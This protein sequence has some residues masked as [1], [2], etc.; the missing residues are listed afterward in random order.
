MVINKQIL[1]DRLEN[2]GISSGSAKVSYSWDAITHNSYVENN[3]AASADH[4]INSVI[5][6][7]V[8]PGLSVG[9]TNH[10]V[11]TSHSNSTNGGEFEFNDV[12]SVG[13]KV[14]YD[15][16]TA[17]LNINESLCGNQTDKVRSRVLLTSM[18]DPASLSGFMVGVNGSNK[19]FYEYVNSDGVREV[20]VLNHVIGDR[21]LISISNSKT[22]NLVTMG[23]Y[24]PVKGVGV[25]SSF[26]INSRNGSDKLYVGGTLSGIHHGGT[27]TYE[28]D[29]YRGFKGY[30]ENFLLLSGYHDESYLNKISDVFFL[31]AYT[32]GTNTTSQISYNTVTGFS[33]TQVVAGQGITGYQMLT[34]NVEDNQGNITQVLEETPM[35]GNIYENKITYLTG[36]DT[37]SSDST[38]FQA[39][40]KTFDNA[41]IKNY[42][43]PCILWDSSFS[44]TDKYEVYRCD[45]HSNKINLRSS[46]KNRDLFPLNTG[47]YNLG[48]KINVYVNGKIQESGVDYQITAN[49]ELSGVARE[50]LEDD[51]V[52]Y[53]IIDEDQNWFDFT[54]WAGTLT[55]GASENKDVYL[56]K[57][58]LIS[59]VDYQ[60]NGSNL[61]IFATN[62]A[63]GRMA[64]IPRHSGT[65]GNYNGT[66]TNHGNCFADKII[67]E[68]VWVG[69]L[70]SSEKIDYNKKTKCDISCDDPDPAGVS[71][72]F[73]PAKINKVFGSPKMVG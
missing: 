71:A 16:W 55:Y 50:Y 59:G 3:L 37:A 48:D 10:P 41:Y 25:Y 4:V 61:E 6:A 12:L 62:F 2:E 46:R 43:N 29:N 38:A 34:V 64:L 44:N 40:S 28:N 70:R 73:V 9:S 5:N 19:L 8:K 42:A 36:P 18:N 15:N 45:V 47:V 51:Y 54:G 53:D 31:T 27:P 56:N 26:G 65:V 57:L 39:E 7:S 13:S 14:E 21:N 63:T 58:K 20:E 32:R 66:L 24:D 17:F 23:V 22:S 60:L 33:E 72:S 11:D 52:V 30:V 69:G 67:S 68:Q 49:S 35:Y 1:F